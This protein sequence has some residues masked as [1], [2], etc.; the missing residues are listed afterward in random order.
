MKKYL[1]LLFIIAALS[2]TSCFYN[3]FCLDGNGEIRDYEISVDDFVNIEVEGSVDIYLNNAPN[4]GS[5]NLTV[6][7]NLKDE[8]NIY[9][10]NGTLYVKSENICPTQMEL[11]ID[12][13]EFAEIDI[14]GSADI[15]IY[16][17]YSMNKDVKFIIDGS[18]EI[19]SSGTISANSIRFDCDGSGEIEINKITAETVRF[20][21]DGSCD[22]NTAIEC[23]DLLIDIDGSG[24]FYTTGGFY[25]Y[26]NC[27]I[28][29]SGDMNLRYAKGKECN[30]SIDGSGDIKVDVSD[31][32]NGIITGSGNIDIWGNPPVDD[33]DIIGS[34]KINR[35]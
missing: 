5:I 15:V 31:A 28:S 10:S 9:T 33:I 7:E 14:D 29:G 25:D 32:I 4:P 30:F 19:N 11:H 22:V 35:H 18:V 24:D 27:S 6:D 3:P 26:F 13:E 17:D 23:T 2:L 16:D 21:V 20:S 8:I 1:Y 12:M 34:G